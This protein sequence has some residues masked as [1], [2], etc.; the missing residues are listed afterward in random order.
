M[1]HTVVN[2]DYVKRPAPKV[3]Q[4][5][6]TFVVTKTKETDVVLIFNSVSLFSYNFLPN[7]QRV[8]CSKISWQEIQ[9][10]TRVFKMIKVTISFMFFLEKEMH[11]TTDNV[12]TPDYLIGC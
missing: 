1:S 10:Q 12:L 7:K 5:R 8:F 3:T 9:K 2:I 11:G 4:I 6:L